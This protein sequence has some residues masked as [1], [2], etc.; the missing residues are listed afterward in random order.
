MS[1]DDEPIIRSPLRSS[2]SDFTARS[3]IAAVAAALLVHAYGFA[4]L[5]LVLDYQVHAEETTDL[6]NDMI[7]L[8][9]LLGIDYTL[10]WPEVT[11]VPHLSGSDPDG[12]GG[13]GPVTVFP[14]PGF[15]NAGQGGGFDP[16]DP[17]FRSPF[18][19]SRRRESVPGNEH[20]PFL[21]KPVDP[22]GESCHPPRVGNRRFPAH[23]A[24][25]GSESG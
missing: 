25:S 20:L 16:D 17:H 10:N 18:P 3:L 23:A 9:P 13:S 1:P 21:A 6:A 19:P 15:A 11:A 22:G 5:P 12:L 8:D 24:R 14:P 7:S 4:I 2:G